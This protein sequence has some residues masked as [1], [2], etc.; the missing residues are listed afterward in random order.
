MLKV[1]DNY[2][3]DGNCT[4]TPAVA[5]RPWACSVECVFFAKEKREKKKRKETHDDSSVLCTA[6]FIIAFSVVAT[7]S[8]S[9]QRKQAE[10]EGGAPLSQRV[11]FDFMYLPATIILFTSSREKEPIPFKRR[12]QPLHGAV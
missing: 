1:P 3:T 6:V 7:D 12:H 4:R 5:T 9:I 11:R 8:G 2:R 10:D